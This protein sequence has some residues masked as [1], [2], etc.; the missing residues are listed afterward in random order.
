[1]IGC[2]KNSKNKLTVNYLY[3]AEKFGAKVHELHEV[4]ELTPLA[5]GG[6]EVLTRHPGWVQRA[7]HVDRHRYTAKEVIVSAHAYGSA[8]LLHHM[9][10]VGKLSRLSDQLG[11]LARTNSEQLL[12]QRRPYGD[13][14][15]DPEQVHI[16]PGSVSITS[17][18]WPDP[19]TSIEPV[20]YGVGSDLM[21]FL[22]TAHQE[23]EQKHPFGAG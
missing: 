12:C 20:M 22:L 15:R 10:H 14:K 11:Q 3:L 18:V 16:T 13:W 5:D 8:K 4:Y 2:G 7:A 6:F 9:R 17:G 21:G 23:G 19:Q 1:M